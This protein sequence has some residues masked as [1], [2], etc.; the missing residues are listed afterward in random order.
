MAGMFNCDECGQHIDKLAESGRYLERTSPKGQEFVGQCA[1]ACE[2][3]E[4]RTTG[5]TA[6]KNC[7]NDI[8]QCGAEEWAEHS[9]DDVPQEPGIYTFRG[10]ARFDEDSSE[11]STTCDEL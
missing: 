1:P 2:Y 11:Y 5:G 8:E 6:L 3:H 7:L 4:L 10:S 9:L